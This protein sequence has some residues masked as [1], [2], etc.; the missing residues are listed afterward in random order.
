MK[1]TK[2]KQKIHAPAAGRPSRGLQVGLGWPETGKDV[3][4]PDVVPDFLQLSNARGQGD[5][6]AEGGD[7]VEAGDEVDDVDLIPHSG[8]KK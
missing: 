7:D 1:K 3:K 5:D 4:L 6:D 2:N 8:A